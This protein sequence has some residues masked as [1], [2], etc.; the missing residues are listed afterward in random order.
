MN[1][2]QNQTNQLPPEIEKEMDDKFLNPD[3]FDSIHQVKPEFR[4]R[5]YQEFQQF[6][7]TQLA[8]QRQ[9]LI[10][11]I[12]DYIPTE[13]QCLSHNGLYKNPVILVRTLR[14]LFE[15]KYPK[16]DKP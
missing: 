7:A 1:K 15:N 3:K 11:E 6:L 8:K 10:K 4:G 12:L 5:L 13:K 2:K 14:T 16:E 9:E